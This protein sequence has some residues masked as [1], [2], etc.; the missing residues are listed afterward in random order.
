MTVAEEKKIS[1]E[2]IE[3]GEN[4]A[5]EARTDGFPEESGIAREEPVSEPALPLSDR[6]PVE[7]LLDWKEQI[8]Q[9]VLLELKAS[10]PASHRGWMARISKPMRW[11]I[12]AGI[13][14]FLLGILVGHALNDEERGHEGDGGARGG[15]E[16]RGG[17]D[18]GRF[19]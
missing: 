9:E 8:K 3:P 5:S 12:A 1:P 11:M 14:A 18:R 15:Y 10:P 4:R 13:L 17:H 6:A 16:D 7:P 2:P 19:R